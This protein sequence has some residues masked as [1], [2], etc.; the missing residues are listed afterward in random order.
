MNSAQIII[1]TPFEKPDTALVN[2]LRKTTAFPVLHV[3]RD[4]DEA[5]AAL[6]QVSRYEGKPFGICLADDSPYPS[7]IPSQVNLLILPWGKP[8]PVSY[9]GEVL[10]QVTSVTDAMAA[11]SAGF[12]RIIVKGSESAGKVGNDS[13]FI[14]FQRIKQELPDIDVWVQGG[15]GVHTTAGLVALGAKGV[16]LDSQ[17]ALF[18]E[19]SV[20]TP[21][22]QLCEKLSGNETRIIDGFRVLVRPNSPALTEGAGWHKLQPLLGELDL[23]EAYVPMGQDIAFA[24]GMAKRYGKITNLIHALYDAIQGHIRQ[25]KAV[26]VLGMGNTMAKDLGTDYPIAQGPMTRVSDVPA[27][28]HAVAEAG[29]L[30]FVALS[31]MKGE[32]AKALITETKARVAD[33]PWGVGILGFVPQELR[34]EQMAY[35]MAEKPPFALIAGGRPSQSAA[36]EKMGISAF[37]HVP[38]MALLDLFLKEGAAKFVF[39][40]RECG[41]HVGPLSSLVLWEMQLTRLLDEEQ[42]ERLHVFFAGGIHDALSASFVAVMAAPL[43]ARGG[44]VGVLMGTA[45]L[46]TQEAVETGAILKQ[47]QDHALM[48]SETVLLETAPGHETRCLDSPFAGFFEMEKRKMASETT[49]K[50][51]IWA[52]LEALNVG[53]LRIASKGKMRKGPQLVALTAE[54]RAEMGM[55]MIGQVVSLRHEIVTMAQL[56]SEVSTGSQKLIEAMS[57]PINP[58]THE[59][60]GLDIAIVGMACIYPGASNM[61][62]FWTNVLLAKDCITEV[63]DERWN[64]AVYY[65]PDAQHGEKSPSKWG[66]FIP[67]VAFDPLAFGIPPQSLAAIDPTQLLSLLVAKQALDDAGYGGDAFNG[68]DVSVIIGAEGGHDLANNYGFRALFPQ[69]FGQMPS[70]LDEALPRLTE[71]SFPGVLANVI[72]GR[73]T[74]RLNLGGR[75]YTVDAACASSLAALDLAC[76]ELLL[77]KS[78]M[79]LAGAADLHNSINDYLLFAS[80]HALSRK[81]RCATFDSEAD[82][83]ALGEG[84]AMVVLKRHEDAIA[85]K[86]KIYA[87]IKGIGGSSDGKSLGLT[88]P[89]KTGQLR[90]L[91]RAYWQAGISAADVGM[92][93]AHGTGTV[94]GDRTEMSAL[95]DMWLAAGAANKSTLLGSVKTQIGH[96]KCAAGLAGVIKAALSVYHGIKPPTLHLNTPNPYYRERFSPF[97]FHVAATPWLEEKRRAGV[98]AFGFGGTNFHAIL[99]HPSTETRNEAVMKVWP[100]ELF[101]FRGT[102]STEALEVM[103]LAE[104]LMAVNHS[105]PFKDIAYSLA[106]YSD[107]PVQYSIVA[108]SM[109]ELLNK[110]ALARTGAVD[111]VIHYTQPQA[112]QVAL[113]F[114]GQGSQRIGMARQLFLAFPSLR[115]WLE[116]YPAYADVLFPPATFDPAESVRQRERMKDTRMAQPLLGIVDYA[117]ADLLRNLGVVP[118][119]LV[120]HSYGELPALCFAGVFSEDLLVPLSEWRAKAILDAVGDD[121][122][123]MLAVNASQDAFSELANAEQGVYAV[124]HNSPQQWVLA[125]GTEAITAAMQ[126]LKSAG[127]P[128]KA[129]D[130]AC[131]FHSPLIA[132][133]KST[134]R[135]MLDAVDFKPAG[136][137]VWSN[138]TAQP[139]PQTAVGIKEQLAEHL[140]KPVRFVEE[141][142][143]LYAQGTRIFIEVGPGNVLSGLTRSIVGT[144]AHIIH[145]EDRNQAGIAHFLG[146][147]A[148]Y[149]ATGRDLKLQLLFDGREARLLDLHNIE[150]YSHSKSTWWVNGQLA[151]PENGKIPSYAALPV[152]TPLS[153]FSSIPHQATPGRNAEPV[154][155]IAEYLEGMRQLAQS[156]RDV[157]LGYLGQN[158]G[159][160]PSVADR[161]IAE[162]GTGR[163]I[164]VVP[165]ATTEVLPPAATAALPLKDILLHIV[166]DKTGYP[167]DMLG[168]DLDLEADLSIDSIKRM[169]I[170]G[171]LRLQLGGFSKPDGVEDEALME[172][173]AGIKTLSALLE[174]ITQYR[175]TTDA[176]AH[177]GTPVTLPEASTR[178]TE[179]QIK[180][181]LLTVV[182]DKT[183]YP[184][185]MLGMDLDLEAD[186]SIDSI[187]RMEIMGEVKTQMGLFDKNSE[188]DDERLM[189]QMASIKSLNGLVEWVKNAVSGGLETVAEAKKILDDDRSLSDE[190]TDQNGLSRFRFGALSV[191]LPDN[192]SLTFDG[193]HIAILGSGTWSDMMKGMLE[194]KGATVDLI[195]N[196]A[197][198]NLP[199][200]DGLIFPNLLSVPADSI[201]LKAALPILKGL[202][203][204]KTKWVYALLESPSLPEQSQGFAGLLKSLGHEWE[205][206]SCRVIHVESATGIEQM[207]AWVLDELA[208]PEGTMEIVYKEGLRH[209]WQHVPEDLE[210]GHS[211]SLALDEEDVILVFGGAQ[212]I[213]AQ[214]MQHVANDSPCR[215]VLV[216]RTPLITIEEEFASLMDFETIKKT[217]IDSGRYTSPAE[218]TRRANEIFKTNQIRESLA[219]FGQCGAEVS[220]HSLD[221]QDGVALAAFIDELYATYGRIDGVVHGAGLLEDK[222]FQ[223]KSIE[224]FER[225]YDTKVAPLNILIDRLR[226]DGLKFM[227]LFSSVAS[228]F[229]NRGQTDY[230]AANSVL[231]EFA[232]IQNKR[233]DGKV[234]A[235]N[236][237]PWKGAG[238]VSPGLERTYKRRGIKLIPLEQGKAWFLQELKY[239]QDSQVLIMAGQ[240]TAELMA[241]T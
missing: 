159:Q 166:S 19:C 184:A 235:I 198:D 11:K 1:I 49:D 63:P 91:E 7:S 103:T 227:V 187:K 145:T 17:V 212:G 110:M 72:A 129:L 61:D 41:G 58:E 26:N 71:D 54:Q 95:S 64:K 77:G 192:T 153:T 135:E 146:A 111:K 8:I 48:H 155:L 185:D 5:N 229:G 13:A 27:F 45:Y 46:Y 100:A 62:E 132:G 139:Y 3:G 52:K 147:I 241:Q 79:V 50:K 88:A 44:K 10:Y 32:D 151:M 181:I 152:I 232:H 56:H 2:R 6:I 34:D 191:P 238:M 173:L 137:T 80:T 203:P 22:K 69:L 78:D 47:F 215:Y 73:I 96:T 148:S 37:L 142:E 15:A 150:Q 23:N 115:N 220:Y 65:D 223:Q 124:N 239:G 157:M 231:D 114:S 66:G 119:V 178:L 188:T 60:A 217:L 168:M 118:D 126:R 228:V 158:P 209:V 53:R 196:G 117:L 170:I 42:A 90:A 93:E 222:L 125:G 30:P 75:N 195:H 28:A 210:T 194:E 219:A 190:D 102:S 233:I 164:D 86:D 18:A 236:W 14:L 59:T 207:A 104:K 12:Q 84:I 97:V 24:G 179:S 200:Y 189:E 76:Q 113:L 221:L 112:G 205:Q 36:L 40:G 74:N 165:A 136:V 134:Y 167:A 163:T 68:D 123:M 128:C 213:T 197:V 99:E 211:A 83:I 141:I 171:E 193:E 92:V 57:K 169:E 140:V 109:E 21:L 108:T 133:A 121:K 237:G 29:A 234:M 172:D 202:A 89:R 183:G 240:K 216:G 39:E 218:I 204:D 85:D 131:A 206:T 55:F 67:K 186:L 51:E 107:H 143:Q 35:I 127:I 38:A 214:L 199:A 20:P 149:M 201:S 177:E 33:K 208:H 122:G 87:V 144:D 98:S 162:L 224:S 175:P 174:W 101:V 138:T 120:G 94:V 225:V 70:E 105:L 82:G 180:T 4:A 31:L 226:W 81:G 156:Q 176:P 230:A 116:R 25:A 16:V 43:A 161:P 106:M 182:S 154:Q 130:V 9:T 160:Q